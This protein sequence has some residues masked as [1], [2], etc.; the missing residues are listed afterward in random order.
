MAQTTINR[1]TN[2]YTP[3]P[4]PSPG[5]Y[6]TLHGLKQSAKLNGQLVKVH[7]KIQNH[8]DPAAVRYQVEIIQTGARNSA[9]VENLKNLGESLSKQSTSQQVKLIRH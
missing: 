7:E 4:H 5:S 3:R 8:E 9:K 6:Y 2:Y 1:S